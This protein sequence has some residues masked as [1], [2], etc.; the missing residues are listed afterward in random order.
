M[1]PVVVVVVHLVV[2]EVE[3][4]VVTIIAPQVIRAVEWVVRV[5]LVL[6]LTRRLT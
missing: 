1:V 6:V 2:P 3:V 4:G 5:V